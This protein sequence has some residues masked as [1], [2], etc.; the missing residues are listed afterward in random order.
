LFGNTTGVDVVRTVSDLRARVR[1]AE[2]RVG[3]LPAMGYE[4]TAFRQLVR[5]RD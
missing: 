4:L 5:G 2:A 1:D 3:S